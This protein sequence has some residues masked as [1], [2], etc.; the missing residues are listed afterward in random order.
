MAAAGALKANDLDFW[1]DEAP[2]PVAPAAHRAP[3]QPPAGAGPTGDTIPSPIPA[4]N[5]NWD[6][7]PAELEAMWLDFAEKYA[8]DPV[9]FAQDVL[10]IRLMRHQRRILQAVASGARRIAMR[11]GHRVGKT[12]IMA[13]L[14]LWHLCTKYPQKTIVTAP[15][16]GQLYGALLPEI[17]TISKR[18]PPFMRDL[19]NFYTDGIKLKADPDGSFLVARTADPDN[20]EGF[21]G[22]HSANILFIWDEASGID[23]RLFN[24]ARGS[25]ASPNAI[26]VLAGNPTRLH[27]TFHKAFTTH[28]ELYEKFHVSSLG[29]PTVAQDF[30]DEIVTEFGEDSNEYRIRVL[31][32]FPET[33]DESYIS[34]KLVKAART[35]NIERPKMSAVV[36]SLD[37]SRSPEG[38]GDP[39]VLTRR[40][41]HH[42]VADQK[43]Y[44]RKD[45]MQMVGEIIKLADEDR[46][47]LIREFKEAG[48]SLLFL[49]PVPVA[50][51][52]DVIGI[53]A[54]IVDRLREL[55]L[56][57]IA[58]NASESATDEVHCFRMRDAL[59]KKALKY[60]KE[61]VN[62][63]PDDDL[64]E[65]ELTSA[66]YE[67]N[68]VGDLIIESKKSMK[69][70]GLRSPD[71]AD[72]LCLNLC[73][74]PEL[75]SSFLQGG[76]GQTHGFGT[77]PK[78]LNRGGNG[79]T[80]R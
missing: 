2:D 44:R 24:A 4:Q 26:R 67:Y 75:I 6:P 29:L 14:C 60:L 79:P 59:W 47:Q 39:S 27:N 77:G 80:T 71:R 19:F 52:V 17:M 25:M 53:G 23:D 32:E 20:P 13:V 64:L 5:D 63:L 30:I 33:D 66:R 51:V 78:T 16:A 1:D 50:I 55:G 46:A 34:S 31:G 56:P 62:K 76:P 73:C 61:P 15:S 42:F 70:R 58:V 43:V 21:Q 74:P 49:P 40:Y 65:V 3:P 8:P 69:K 36:Y 38:N 48:R 7:T 9:A 41:G 10:G 22:I 35:R 11:S 57:V 68:S 54:G 45:T 28:A 18:L 12:L 72:S 37:P